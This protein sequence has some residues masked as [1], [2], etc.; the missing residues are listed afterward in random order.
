MKSISTETKETRWRTSSFP[1]TT[2]LLRAGRTQRRSKASLTSDHLVFLFWKQVLYV[3]SPVWSPETSP[4]TWK[5][6]FHFQLGVSPVMTRAIW[7]R[8]YVSC[9]SDCLLTVVSL[10]GSM[11]PWS[12]THRRGLFLRDNSEPGAIPYHLP[13]GS[14]EPGMPR[15]SCVRLLK[16][17][18]PSVSKYPVG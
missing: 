4:L 17:P 16:D 1:Q 12:L 7:N 11:W 9:Y 13:G 10:N 6:I 3:W 18:Y 15:P 5:L 8:V 14:V 2:W